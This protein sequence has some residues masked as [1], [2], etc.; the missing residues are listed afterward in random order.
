MGASK[1]AVVRAAAR[2]VWRR[3]H[4]LWWIYALNF[5]LALMGTLPF[6]LRLSRVLDRSLAAER[7]YKGFDLTVFI[8][9]VTQPD[10]SLR[11]LVPG[12]FLFTLLFFVTMLFLTGGIL[13][14]YRY[15]R[16]LK[17]GEFFYSCGTFFRP[18]VRLLG[19]LLIVLVPVGVLFGLV[20]RW[21][22]RL[23][24]DAPWEMLGF[25]VQVGGTMVMLFLF[26]VVR[27][28]F[29]MAQVCAVA[30]GELRMRYAFVRGYKLTFGNFGVLIWIYLR[31][32]LAT[33]VGL[34]LPLWVWV[35]LVRPEWVAVS[36]LVGQALV[37]WWLTA[38]L[39]LRASE[40][41]WYQEHGPAL[42][43]EYLDRL[44]A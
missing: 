35:E 28:W 43:A 5:S 21:S 38:R 37:L 25:W 23:A 41:L 40:T 8:E 36:F 44:V 2:L 17:P 32:L 39:W 7:L 19:L 26:M 15:D 1:A 20:Q 31:I 6:S 12:S 14:A 16:K 42:S 22:N 4:I 18:F 29:D 9:L 13:E 33:A 11:A 27:L 34:V 3:Q 24:A 30:E 10:V